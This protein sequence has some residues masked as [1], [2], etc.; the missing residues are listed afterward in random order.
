M[1]LFKA[2]KIDFLSSSG[3]FVFNASAV[4]VSDGLDGNAPKLMNVVIQSVDQNTEKGDITKTETD[5]GK[6]IAKA[7]G[8]RYFYFYR[9]EQLTSEDLKTY[10]DYSG[11]KAKYDK[12][13]LNHIVYMDEN[14][15]GAK[16]KPTLIGLL[17]AICKILRLDKLGKKLYIN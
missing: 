16:P 10:T 1:N 2:S 7:I 6:D 8:A 4:S 15:P 12:S 3:I 5:I 13:E 11:L 14:A 17:T 9:G